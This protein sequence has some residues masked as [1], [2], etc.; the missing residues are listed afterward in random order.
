VLQPADTTGHVSTSRALQG[1]VKGLNIIDAWTQDPRLPTYT[2]HS[3]TG[4]IR[5][6]R[7]YINK[8]LEARKTG[9]ETLPAA[10]TDHEAVILRIVL[11]D[12]DR[13]RKSWRWRIDPYIVTEHMQER[14]RQEWEKCSKRGQYYAYI[15][16]WWEWCAKAQLQRL[17][18]RE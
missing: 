4:A 10:F 2:Y 5:I 14:I 8:E 6:G 16:M 13:R 18:R 1:I 11:G 9:M 12:Q 3:P 15:T 7:F 17:L